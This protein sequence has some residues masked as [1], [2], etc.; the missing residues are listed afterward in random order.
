[1]A[2]TRIA[3]GMDRSSRAPV[4]GSPPGEE[5]STALAKP[6]AGPEWLRR[7]ARCMALIF[8]VALLQLVGCQPQPPE[9]VVVY[10]ALD[11]VFSKPILDDFAEQSGIEVL[12]KMD[13]E[14]TKTVGLAQAIMAERDRPRCDLFWN[15]EVL[16]TLRLARAGLLKPVSIAVGEKYPAQYR[17]TDGTWYG[18][19]ARGRV[20]IVNTNKITEARRPKS[21]DALIDPQ[22]RDQCGIAKPLAGTTA[23]HAACLFATWGDE[24]AER[25]FQKV[26][27]NAQ[28]LSGNRDVARRVAT[29]AL[30]FGL[31]DTDDAMVE[32]DA[33]APVA[34]VYPDQREDE[35][36]TL[37]IPN[38]L[39]V[40]KGCAHPENAKQLMAHLLQPEVEALLVR[41]PS[42]QIP[43]HPESTA[44]S[45]VETPKTVKAMQV[46]FNAA[47]D[48]WD[49]AYAF[50]R[51]EFASAK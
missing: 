25:F 5:P 27:G 28:I 22:W 3:N 11:E 10:T 45:R 43:L 17:S 21:I 46:D 2:V 51:D 39:A 33:G 23:T 30:A 29:G 42:A 19:A 50:L 6:I 44:K 7:L 34:I 15:N 48:K 47:A 20:L 31:T 24:E 26:K 35:L 16:H 18:F 36:G 32:I 38:T 9:Q 8:A 4:A 40:I 1:M 13:T 12:P 49:V 41:G 14:S 37:F